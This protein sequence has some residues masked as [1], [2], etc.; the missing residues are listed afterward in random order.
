[1]AEAPIPLFDKVPG[2]PKE[3]RYYR[4]TRVTMELFNSLSH[5]EIMELDAYLTNR[6]PRTYTTHHHPASDKPYTVASRA[7]L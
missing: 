7:K 1:M 5:R 6:V 2:V 4:N 3:P